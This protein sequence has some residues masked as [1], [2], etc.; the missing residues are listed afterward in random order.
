MSIDWDG[1]EPYNPD[2][3][4]PLQQLPHKQARA[5]YER[6]MATKGERIEMLKRLLVALVCRHP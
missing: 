6:M 2:V 1:Y 5:A 4:R 3:D